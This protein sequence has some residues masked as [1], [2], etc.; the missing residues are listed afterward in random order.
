MATYK[1]KVSTVEENLDYVLYSFYTIE[2][3]SFHHAC[4]EAE[5]K[6]INMICAN[7][8]QLVL[9]KSELSY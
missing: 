5:N 6:F 9:V 2:S 7:K 8:P 4:A 1:I 3:D